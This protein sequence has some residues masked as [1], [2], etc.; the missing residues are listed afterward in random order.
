MPV[1]LSPPPRKAPNSACYGEEQE[2]SLCSRNPL[3]TRQNFRS[4]P[5]GQPEFPLFS[6]KIDENSLLSEVLT[7]RPV[8]RR[9]PDPPSPS[10]VHWIHWIFL[11]GRF[12]SANRPAVVGTTAR[13][14]DAALCDGMRQADIFPHR[15][16]LITGCHREQLATPSISKLPPGWQ[17]AQV[18]TRRLANP[19][20]HNRSERWFNMGFRFI[21]ISPLR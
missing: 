13:E 10:I 11:V 1:R 4:L 9:L 15:I 3:T 17:R 18:R 8:R 21:L 14:C 6:P 20:R 19:D 16:P 2:L 12:L 7:T 5:E